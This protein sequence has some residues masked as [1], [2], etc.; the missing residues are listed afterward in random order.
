VFSIA[1]RSDAP[2]PQCEA[3]G[4]DAWSA[5]A[6]QQLEAAFARS[7]VPYARETFARVVELLDDHARGWTTASIDAC[8]VRTSGGQAAELAD[9]RIRCLDRNRASVAALIDILGRPLDRTGVDRAVQA[10]LDLPQPASCEDAAQLETTPEPGL[11]VRARVAAVRG[12]LARAG[13][14]RAIGRNDEAH[15]LARPAVAH[16]RELAFPPLLAQ[17]LADE[18]SNLTRAGRYADAEAT[19]YEA[20]RVAAEARDDRRRATLGLLLVELVGYRGARYP[21]ARALAAVAA[22]DIVRAGNE[23][24]LRADLYFGLGV[25]DAAQGKYDDALRRFE[26]WRSL[27]DKEIRTVDPGYAHGLATI[28]DLYETLA[29]LD[30]ALALHERA[31]GIRERVLGPRHPLVGDSLNN[32]GVVLYRLGRYRDADTAYRKALAI[33][34]HSHGPEHPLVASTLNNLAGILEAEGRFEEALPV[35]DRAIAIRTKTLGADHPRVAIV[36]NNLGETLVRMGRLAD[37]RQ[38]F[39][40][41]LAIREAKLGA[42]HPDLAPPLMNLGRV[43]VREGR[44]ADAERHL[45]RALVLWEKAFGA[46]H[47]NLSYPRAG[48]V[49]VYLATGRAAQAVPIAEAVL[50]A[51]DT[52]NAVPAELAEA[53][54]LLARARWDAGVDGAGARK[55]AEAARDD[56]R[57]LSAGWKGEL[58]AVEAWLAARPP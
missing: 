30:E 38:A 14:L 40:R 31:L 18:A 44:A 34:E 2:R 45:R 24:K 55:L 56:Y 7:T 4:L 58:A 25:L 39:E 22:A 20:I 27:T 16:A 29:R 6:R 43:L 11:F 28:A 57:K 49:E 26:E 33:R 8:R 15:A 42:E 52:P 13:A 53:R 41:S 47:A 48:L 19:A 35:Y 1:Q 37:G 36:F 5:A 51:R 21:E 17:A 9:R 54:F 12:V 3:A 46:A 32:M 50:T 10:V 23:V